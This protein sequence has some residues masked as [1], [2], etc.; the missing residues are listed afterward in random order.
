ME[1][2]DAHRHL[3]QQNFTLSGCKRCVINGT[4]PADWEGILT[5]A[6][7]HRQIIPAIGLHPWR[8]NNAPSNWQ[9][10]FLKQLPSAAAVGEIGLDQWIESYDAQKQADAFIWQLQ[11]ASQRNLPVSI[12]CLKASN[13]LIRILK[14]ERL[15]QRGIHLHAYSGSAEQVT[16]LAD[17]GA[18]FSFHAGQLS[19]KA[20]KAPAA[21]RAVPAERLLIETDSPD[22]LKHATSD[23]DFLQSGYHKAAALRGM[24]IEALAE[25]VAANFIRY[26]LSD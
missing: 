20:K 5:A 24:T 22:T 6:G 17:L 19:N 14:A 8:V 18:Y 4:E 25:Q 9:S 23:Q 10:S 21:L 15:P 13:T 2:Y 11:Q 3:S 7:Q 1:F 26:F 12:H 16:Q